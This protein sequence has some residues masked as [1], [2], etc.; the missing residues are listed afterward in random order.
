MLQIYKN[1]YIKDKIFDIIKNI[2]IFK[3]YGNV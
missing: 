1:F 2:Y 3:I